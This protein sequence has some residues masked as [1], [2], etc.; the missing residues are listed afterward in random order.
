M[1]RCVLFLRKVFLKKGIAAFLGAIL[2]ELV[3]SPVAVLLY[4]EFFETSPQI[5]VIEI[6]ES[7]NVKQT[8]IWRFRN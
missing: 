8:T 5:E 2:F 6:V 1:A 4:G 7:E 3:I